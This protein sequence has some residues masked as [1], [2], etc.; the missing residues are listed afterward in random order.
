MSGNL[1]YANIVIGLIVLAWVVSRQLRTRPVREEQATKL[2]LVLGAVGLYEV[3]QYADRHHDVPLLAW[4]LLIVSLVLAAVLGVARGLTMRVWRDATGQLLQRGTP[5][6]LALWGLS[7]A[8][9]L[10]AD[11]LMHG[12]GSNASG[13]GSAGIVLYLALTLG[14]QRVVVVR[15]GA[16]LVEHVGYEAPRNGERV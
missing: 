10:G 14:V 9:H 16:E 2:L 8:A 1:G 3:A 13:L 4:G 7:I 12:E 5:V 6:T 15:R 11:A